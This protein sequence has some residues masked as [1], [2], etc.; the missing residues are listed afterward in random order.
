MNRSGERQSTSARWLG[1]RDVVCPFGIGGMITVSNWIQEGHIIKFSAA[2][3]LCVFMSSIVFAG[4]KVSLTGAFESGEF[5]ASEGQVDAFVVRTLPSLQSGSE[6]IGTTSGGGDAA[7]NWDTRVV[8]SESVGGQTVT[9][10]QGK[11]FARSALYYDKDYTGLNGGLKKARSSLGVGGSHA[12]RV[13]FDT[14]AYIGFSIFVPKNFEDETGTKGDRGSATLFVLNSDSSANFVT[15]RIF[16][17]EGKSEA[18][19]FIDYQKDA[20]SVVANRDFERR[21]DLGP[22]AADKGKWS[23]FVIRFRSNPFSVTTNPAKLGIPNAND[24][25]YQGNKGILQVWKAEGAADANGNRK[26]NRKISV[27]NAPVGNVPGATQGKS[28]L[29][30]SL[31]IYKYNWQLKPTSVKG[32]VWFGFDEFRLGETMRDG[33]AYIDV[34]PTGLACTDGCPAGSASSPA[35]PGPPRDLRTTS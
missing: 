19:W 28:T 23:D 34:H 27:V 11:F 16:V 2:F 6:Y 9:P 1:R 30:S 4:P 22:V 7:S 12:N 10:R 8:R 18:H 35:P 31:R 14:E 20:T 5:K 3:L 24:K 29:G 21:V 33:T 17:P 25:T 32:P 26:M 13:D 15:L